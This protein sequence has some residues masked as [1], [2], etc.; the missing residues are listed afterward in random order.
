MTTL[1]KRLSTEDGFSLMESVMAMVI[2]IIL[3]VSVAVSLQ[4]IMRHQRDVR[5]RQQA[6]ALVIQELEA[7]R[8][9]PWDDLE[10]IST[11]PDDF[12]DG[13]NLLGAAVDLP[14]DEP[15][16]V[17]VTGGVTYQD[18][19]LETYDGQSFDVSRYVSEAGTDLRRIVVVVSWT[20]NGTD[21]TDLAS[22]LLAVNG[23]GTQ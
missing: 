14:A 19:A 13:V 11:V 6:A 22:T 12:N 7:T 17:D 1:R 2:V 18:V 23:T 16:V 10:M 20:S 4:V 8:I 5:L 9:V 3:F 21:Y 15:L